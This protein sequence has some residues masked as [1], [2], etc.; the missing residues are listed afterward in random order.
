VFDFKACL[1]LI[2]ALAFISAM[3]IRIEHRLTR[4]E[5]RV[6]ERY[7]DKKAVNERIEQV[8]KWLPKETGHK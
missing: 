6:Q 1:E 4:V 3:W 8:E 5:D 7:R 2:G